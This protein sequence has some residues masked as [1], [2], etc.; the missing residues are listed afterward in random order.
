VEEQQRQNAD[1]AKGQAS[2]G[3]ELTDG[4]LGQHLNHYQ[5]AQQKAQV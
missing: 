2:R 4:A 1:S 5:A 3:A